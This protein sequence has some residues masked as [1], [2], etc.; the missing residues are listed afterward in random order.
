M[1]NNP[2]A[3]DL[4]LSGLTEAACYEGAGRFEAELR[5]VLDAIPKYD[6]SDPAVRE[7]VTALAR[8]NSHLSWMLRDRLAEIQSV[9]RNITKFCS[10]EL[11]ATIL[12]D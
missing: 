12:H 8:L 11:A 5:R 3:I 10:P 4:N 7:L 6:G 2:Y 9:R 1:A